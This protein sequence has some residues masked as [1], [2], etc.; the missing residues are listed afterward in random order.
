MGSYEIIVKTEEVKRKS[1]E[2]DYASAQ[3]ILDTIDL[4]KIKNMADLSLMAEVC[5]ENGRYEE[6]MELL[7]RIYN[8][9]KTRK[10]VYLL[11][12]TSIKKMN[13][14]DAEFYLKEYILL[15]PRDF[16]RYIFRYQIDKI[17]GEPYE[18]LI[19]TLRAL[20]ETERIEEWAY[21]LAKLYYKAGMEEECINECS[22]LI[23]WFG[24]GSYVEKAKIL[25]AYYSGEV[26]KDMII[27][28]LKKRAVQENNGEASKKAIQESSLAKEEDTIE[29]RYDIED[30]T[31]VFPGDEASEELS[32]AIK[33]DVEEIFYEEAGEKFAGDPALSNEEQA[34]QEVEDEIYR[35]LAEEDDDENS[36]KLR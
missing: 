26:D 12:L 1:M 5:S 32:V 10:V 19:E 22:D 11:V 8:K 25:K 4:K 18:T 21:E 9:T 13:V 36:T 31:V 33:D 6:A 16:Y 17:K 23:L 2:G 15:A 34:E 7:Q 24:E 28:Q 20:K 29:E 14:E 3:R 35:L 27:S 30:F